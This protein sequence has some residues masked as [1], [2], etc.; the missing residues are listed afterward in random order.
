M[1]PAP[2]PKKSKPFSPYLKYSNLALQ[3]FGVVGLSAWGGYK[4]DQ[5][6]GFTFPVFL[7][8]LVLISFAGMMF[9]VYRSFN[10]E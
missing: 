10:K 7:L 4:L 5:Y 8:S 9:M 1:E 6:L 3:L 2:D